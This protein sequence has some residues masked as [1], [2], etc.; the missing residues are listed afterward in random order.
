MFVVYVGVNLPTTPIM[1]FKDLF[2]F[3]LHINGS[4]P[5]T[6]KQTTGEIVNSCDEIGLGK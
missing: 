5:E 6:I 3:L 1:F 2:N 4:Q